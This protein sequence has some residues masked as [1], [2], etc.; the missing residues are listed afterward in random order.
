MW[1]SM[2]LGLYISKD[3][4]A[5]ASEVFASSAEAAVQNSGGGVESKGH[6]SRSQENEPYRSP[7]GRMCVHAAVSLSAYW[8]PCLQL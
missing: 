4:I 2:R 5:V 1:L 8:P 6:K 3:L 7:A